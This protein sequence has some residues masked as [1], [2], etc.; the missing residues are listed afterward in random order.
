MAYRQ[1]IRA[2]TIFG[3]VQIIQ[4]VIGIVR[5]KFIAV[6]LGPAGIGLIG[7]FQ[8]GTGLIS[9]F[10]NFSLS[11]SA[12][13]SISSAQAEDDEEK[14]GRV[15]AVFRLFVWATGLFGLLLT[16]GLSSYLS[17]ITFGNKGYTGAFA[18][19]S[20]IVFL[21]QISTGQEVL[22]RAGRQVKLM[23]KSSVIGS[24]FGLLAS[25]PFYYFY[26]M[27]GIIPALIITAFASL[28]FSWYFASK[29]NLKK[30]K[31]DYSGIKVEGKEMLK[32]GFII[33]LSGIIT[34][35]F[36]YLVRIFISNY[37]SVTEVGLYNAGFT[38][39]NTYVAM[40]FT[41][42][43]TDYYPKLLGVA[44]NVQKSNEAI[45]QQAEISILILSPLIMIFIVFIKWVVF[46]LYSEAFLPINLMI[47]FAASGTLFKALSWSMSLLVLAKSAGKLFFY[48]ELV[49]SIYTFALNLVGY[50]YYGLTG[51]G[52]SYLI[53]YS[54]YALQVFFVSNKLFGFEMNND[55][56]LVFV[57]NSFL[58]IMC[59]LIV[60][61]SEE[62]LL[63][64]SL[65]V[66][67]IFASLWFNIY[68]LDKRLVFGT[69]RLRFL[70]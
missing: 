1:I 53:S 56:K 63:M 8:A 15:I 69:R 62:G 24:I 43:G 20:I 13:K 39:V 28:F 64:Y 45:N 59:L 47:L 10:T 42:M 14:V 23:A 65:G 50:Y 61:I 57:I 70:K 9:G 11:T 2:T 58:V 3:G 29:L 38:I 41:A 46:L 36:S 17:Q 66:F 32:M 54:L 60:L 37:G 35:V 21:N 40:I 34:L 6:L 16:L 52:L 51:L 12:I 49:A 67:L 18:L 27:R 26:G 22:L 44:N 25:M 19:L 55:F 33:S 31:I 48:N 7:L 5:S 30:V 68:H 4:I